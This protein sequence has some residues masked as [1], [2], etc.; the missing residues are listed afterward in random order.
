MIRIY[1][2]IFFIFLIING[3]AAQE[4]LSLAMAIEKGLE[5]NFQIKIANQNIEIAKNNNH[6]GTAGR[7]PTVDLS[8]RWA[9]ALNTQN[10]P[11]SFF[12][13]LNTVSS[14][15]TPAATANWV[16]FDGGRV[17]LT[18]EQ[19]EQ[20]ELQSIHNAEVAVEN[21][22]RAIILAY[23]QALI[24]REQIKVLE[25]VLAL[26]RDRI[27]RQEVRQ[28]FGQAG[29]FDILQ[30][31]DAFLNDSTTYL[32][33]NNTF[34]NAVRNL[35][36]A[37]GEDDFSKTYNLTDELVYD[38]PS[39]DLV[40]LTEELYA[41]NKNLQSLFINRELANINTK[42]QKTTRS[43]ILSA[44]AGLSWSPTLT[45]GNGVSGTGM[46][47]E[48]D[49]TIARS[50]N[51]NI[52]V[53]ASYNLYDGGTKNRNIENAQ[54]QEIIAQLNVEDLKRT[55][56]A[57][58][59]STVAN[60]NNQKRLLQMTQNL[61]DNAKKNLDISLVRFQAGQISSFDY[62][63]VQLAYINASQARLNAYFNLKVT[64]TDIIQLI[65]GWVNNQ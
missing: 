32:I 55:L 41:K 1:T 8:A 13:E 9:N 53:T 50:F 14:G 40:V 63:S 12:T 11:A 59:A 28:E 24:Q 49:A 33:Q 65:G 17:N 44:G 30:T 26:S 21:T 62:R 36:L 64:E 60:Y 7:Y 54:M 5:N 16:F 19:L 47:I 27:R 46:P 56:S 34:E 51:A 57:Q 25:E 22:V 42:L 38:A 39:Y 58:L 15:I 35:N 48:I 52:N 10:N 23:Y 6:W 45:S 37:M 31:T 29:A 20:L 18:K 4:D 3:L 2:S 43:P 61:L